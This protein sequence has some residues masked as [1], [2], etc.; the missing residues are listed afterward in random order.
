MMVEPLT[1]LP[2]HTWLTLC[3]AYTR[4]ASGRSQWPIRA[5]GAQ[6]TPLGRTDWFY[7][8]WDC[9][10]LNGVSPMASGSVKHLSTSSGRTEWF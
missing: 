2:Q 3:W 9:R 6:G 4:I 10:T 7:S 5:I 8:R 1:L